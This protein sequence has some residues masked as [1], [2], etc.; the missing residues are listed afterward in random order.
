[1]A[2][3]KFS[4]GIFLKTSK[5]FRDFAK[6]RTLKHNL[7]VKELIVLFNHKCNKNVLDG[8]TSITDN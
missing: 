1:M 2:G 5:I 3:G 7:S 6:M 4:T 8:I